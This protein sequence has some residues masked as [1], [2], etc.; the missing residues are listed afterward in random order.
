MPLIRISFLRGK[1][2]EYLSALSDGLHQALVDA[3]EIPLDDRFQIL[4]QHEPSE[5]AFDRTY[6]RGQRSN[7]FTLFEITF[8]RPRSSEAKKVFYQ[9]LVAQLAQSPGL[10]PEDVMTIITT[11]GR[12]DLSM[13]NGVAPAIENA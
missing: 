3:F 2:P 1:S 4:D 12:E 11:T 6:L 8:S 7:D 13:A 10:R 5:L 9:R